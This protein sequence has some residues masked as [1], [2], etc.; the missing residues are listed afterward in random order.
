MG[1]IMGA[2]L[3][4]MKREWK[5]LAIWLVLPLLLTMMT[6]YVIQ[7]VT[8][9]SRI[10]IAVVKEEETELVESFIENLRENELIRVEELSEARA[11]EQLERHEVDSVYVFHKG[12]EAQVMDEQIRRVI[13]AYQ[14]NMSFAYPV[15]SEII[16]S[17]AL[18]DASRAKAAAKVKRLYMEMD[19]IED[20][21]PEA[22]M[23][24]SKERQA[25]SHLL[26]S[27][28][29]YYTKDSQQAQ[30]T[31]FLIRSWGIWALFT[32]I[33]T[34][35]IFDWLLREN[36][37]NM[38]ARWLYTASSFQGYALVSVMMY[39]GLLLVLD[40]I[41]LAVF[42]TVFKERLS[43]SFVLSLFAFRIIINL[44]ASVV[45]LSSKQKIIYYAK[46]IVISLLL[47]LSGGAIIPIDGMM[48]H[49]P[50]IK[51]ISP[52][53]ALLTERIAWSWLLILLVLFV[54]LLRRVGGAFASS[55]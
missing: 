12:Y 35:F 1:R 18:Q 42:S 8:D 31:S 4:R 50:W 21:D 5:T 41:A 28:F 10:P 24:T 29:S 23:A 6:M 43:I 32:M 25:A 7:D 3:I 33:I 30:S 13:S 20:F 53:H 54:I 14:S 38:R 15:T 52:V 2:R 46:A 9:D 26:S 37:P 22:V 34:F 44:L 19:R 40:G 27:E 16:Y 17:L 11:M 36:N 39:T 55:K 47:T 49:F 48:K 45:A 51:W